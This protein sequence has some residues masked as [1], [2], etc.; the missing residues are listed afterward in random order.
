MERGE[1]AV[2]SLLDGLEPLAVEGPFIFGLEVF[3]CA[4][5]M[6]GKPPL[7]RPFRMDRVS[8]RRV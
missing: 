2:F 4:G 5:G 1:D 3:F 7:A 6:G 8:W